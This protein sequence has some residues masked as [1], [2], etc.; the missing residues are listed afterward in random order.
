MQSKVSMIVPCYNKVKWIGGMLQSVNDQHWNNIE[1]ILVNDGSTDGTREVIT[2]WEPKLK[3]R[4][5]EVIII[6]QTNQGPAGAVRTGMLRMSGDYFCTIDCDDRLAC[7]YLT[8]MA[9]WLEDNREY[10]GVSCELEEK[11]WEYQPEKNIIWKH[12]AESPNRLENYIFQRMVISACIYLTRT[13]YIERC[14]VIQNFSTI[15]CFS[16]EPQLNVPLFSNNG[17]FKHIPKGLYL[18][19]RAARDT[20]AIGTV[21]KNMR[22]M[23]K[24]YDLI[25]L[26]IQALDKPFAQKEKL[27]ILKELGRLKAYVNWTANFTEAAPFWQQWIDEYISLVC[28]H[29]SFSPESVRKNV[30]FN[31]I[32]IFFQAFEKWLLNEPQ[33]KMPKIPKGGRIIGYGALGKIAQK[34]LPFLKETPYSPTILWDNAATDMKLDFESLTSN[35]ML[36]ILPASLDILREVKEKLQNIKSEAICVD[37]DTIIDY[38]GNILFPVFSENFYFTPYAA[39]PDRKASF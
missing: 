36:L 21:S 5:Y 39:T 23:E 22:C 20:T 28:K 13:S 18:R 29:F 31:N 19:N 12:S 16:Q 38:L 34:L 15:P 32:R 17:K 11:E 2:E 25:A 24:Y 14:R 37:N 10:D 9:G 6:D 27:F 35:D 3:A 30:S 26:S 4:G 33:E 8:I 7:E 1:L